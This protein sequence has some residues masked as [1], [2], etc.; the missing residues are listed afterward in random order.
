MTLTHRLYQNEFDYHKIR[1]FLTQT[2]LLNERRQINW[3]LSRWDYWRWHVNANIFH[4]NLDEVIHLWETEDG[5]LA[6]VLHPDSPGEVFLQVHPRYRTP[7]LIGE[8]LDIAEKKIPANRTLDIWA[9]EQDD[10]LKQALTQ[11]GYVKQTT[12]E[13]Q[14]WQTLD[15]AVP[16]LP[17]PE[18][19]NLD[20]V[21]AERDLP[22]RSWASWRAF[23]P[24]EP[25]ENYK[26]WEWYYNIQRN[27][28]YR[29][30]LDL[31][32]VAPQGEIA[33]FTTIWWDEVTKTGAFEPVGTV[34]EHQRKGLAKAMIAE[35]LN[36]LKQLG[37]VVAY[38]SSYGMAAH[39]TYE[40]V[41]F[42]KF[43]RSELWK[44]SW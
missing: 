31:V 34:P 20:I 40:S 38:V 14:R 44:K 42:T 27:P 15:R 43:D 17:L 13:Y 32:V 10:I 2:L 18:G 36:R 23:H 5:A 25:D 1:E 19:Y 12:M 37:A 41:G 16:T 7:A 3:H 9:H 22:A 4:L 26:G 30:D 8:M 24:D 21:H 33:S 29:R 35:G 11:R 28:L 39:K 6:A